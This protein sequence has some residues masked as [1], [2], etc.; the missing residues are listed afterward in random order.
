MSVDSATI[1]NRNP[2]FSHHCC[3]LQRTKNIAV[4]PDLN[5]Y[6]YI[7]YRYR[8]HGYTVVIG[9]RFFGNVFT[10]IRFEFE[11]LS[12]Y[13]SV[14]GRVRGRVS[15]HRGIYTR[16][17]HVKKNTFDRCLD[18]DGKTKF[19]GWPERWTD[20]RAHTHTLKSALQCCHDRRRPVYCR[21]RRDIR[22]RSRRISQWVGV[23]VGGGGGGRGSD[24]GSDR[25]PEGS[26]DVWRRRRRTDERDERTDGRTDER[27]QPISSFASYLYATTGPPPDKPLSPRVTVTAGASSAYRE[28]PTENRTRE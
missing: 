7:M 14:C 16:P 8:V 18:E 19:A 24:G 28:R 23:R 22:H 12:S 2:S 26:S 10:R 27:T 4:S 25:C 1:L 5:V 13:T 17:A 6:Q 9:R 20:L 15:K 11:F 21:R 3:R